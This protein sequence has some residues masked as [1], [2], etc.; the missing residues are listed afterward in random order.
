VNAEDLYT[1]LTAAGYPVAYRAFKTAPA[2]P[3]ICYL[4][5]TDHD[6]K[7][8]DSNYQ[9]I[10]EYNVEL[11]SAVKDEAAEAAVEAA[12]ATMGL[13][14]SK[15]EVFIDSEDM[16]EVLYTVNVVR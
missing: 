9:G 14:W 3:Y 6:L 11:Y 8:D 12:L 7:A 2:L 15:S 10:G 1:G 4:F 13:T 16:Y 5:V